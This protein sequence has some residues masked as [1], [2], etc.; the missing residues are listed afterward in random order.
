MILSLIGL[1]RPWYSLP[2][3]AGLLVIASYL[4]AGNFN[5]IHWLTGFLSLYCI[6]SGGYILNDVCDIAVDKINRPGCILSARK[7]SPAASLIAAILTFITG[8]ILAWPV[9]LPFFLVLAAIAAGLIIYDL[10][11]KSM[12]FFKN[13]LVAILVTA[14]YPLAFALTEPVIT[15]RFKV[16][17][18]HPVWLFMTAWGYEM[19]KDILD[20]KGDSLIA[21]KHIEKKRT[22]PAFIRFARILICSASLL[23][24]LPWILGYCKWIYLASSLLAIAL[25]A[26]AAA[27]SAKKAIPYIYAEV[28]L[29]TA[30]S[31]T[32]LLIYGP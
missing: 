20:T 31:L 1:S 25:A 2:L 19:L 11:S 6:I 30:G 15:A 13:I 21:D 8:M 12:G 22:H 14:L 18:I 29:I 28:F 27:K 24:L 4:T 26:I 9:G 23:T 17:F 3:S 16:L 32:D 10:F 5:H 7:I